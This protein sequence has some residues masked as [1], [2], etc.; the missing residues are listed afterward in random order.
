MTAKGPVSSELSRELTLFHITMMGIGMM[1]GAGV[2][3][4]IGN[5]IGVAGPGGVV[6]TFA[7]NGLIAIFTAMSYAELSSAIPRAGGAYNFA[8]IAFG[9]GT[10]F[11][12]GWME[13]FAASVAGS[14]YSLVLG[15]YIVRYMA[16]LGLLGW[17]GD[18]VAVLEKAVAVLAA[19]AFLYINYR[20]VAATGKIGALF[21]LGQTLFLAFIGVV[22]IIVAVR[23]PSRLQNFSPFLPGGWSKLLVTMGFT[24]V[25]FEGFEVIAQA[26]D[27]TIDPKQNIPKA[28]LYSV[29]AVTI[30]YVVVA[31]ATVVAVK[32]GSPGVEGAPWVWIG[33]FKEKGFGEAV[34]RLMPMGNFLLTLA[35]IFSA[36]SALNATLFSA[37]RVSFALGRDRLLP[38]VLAKTSKT[39]RTP[40]VALACTGVIVLIV[41]A[42]LPTMDVASSASM[43]FLLLFFLVNLSVIK[44]RRN[45]GDELQYGF[46]MPL[47]PL[48]PIL[49][50]VMQALLAGWLI[51]MSPI[52][53]IVAP[54]WI[55]I[56]A[57]IYVF[58]G[59][60]HA[61]DTEDEIHVIE[62]APAPPGEGYR[63]MV[64]VESADDAIML[65][66]NAY[67]LCT[68]TEARVEL[69][70]MVPIPEQVSLADAERYAMGGKEGIVEAALYL[71][72]PFPLST[73]MRYC[74][75][76][77]RGIVSAVRQKKIDMVIMGW[78][79][80]H[81]AHLFGLG[82]TVDPVVERSPCNVVIMKD[83]GG[84]KQFRRV[85]VPIAGGRNAAF[86]L[87]VA[88][89][90]VDEKEGEVL[91]FAVNANGRPFDVAQFVEA[92]RESLHCERG[93]VHTKTVTTHDVAGAVLEEAQDCD[94]VVMGWTARPRLSRLAH[95]SV[96][97]AVA[98]SCEKPLIM[99][100]AS[101][102]IQSWLK[103]WI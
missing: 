4:G 9:R 69:L 63:V 96:P 74:R 12:A 70:H 52:A 31:F 50:I 42:F 57:L 39:R 55:V 36:T 30:T 99:V 83:C 21:T 40:A 34:A 7:L 28:M 59:K 58:Y 46:L 78:H 92:N 53:W 71:S 102:G 87:Q 33:S 72:R 38:G 2:F 85:L 84:N 100:K 14:M 64:A 10:S 16:G 5:A 23:D 90:L 75:S 66:R 6:L 82:S 29:F 3:L 11:V 56:G 13:W 22:G 101:G 41:A 94:L 103:R 48:F 25:A 35:V 51:H 27:E 93:L 81:R 15:I 79:G 77:A 26:G 1:I 98:R 20:G 45:M 61:V 32:A 44:I 8:R 67:K 49:A 65:S 80:E 19:G 17:A 43:M 18:N 89:I 76:V 97:V 86:A 24:Y 95:R 88:S 47:F 62:E 54:A 73:S 68:A 37:A 91:A 60:S